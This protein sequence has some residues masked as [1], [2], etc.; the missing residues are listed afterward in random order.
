M[1]RT[2]TWLVLGAFLAGT[3]TGLTARA[4]APADGQTLVLV[5]TTSGPASFS[6]TIQGSLDHEHSRGFDGAFSARVD[7]GR[8]TRI[9][10]LGAEAFFYDSDPEAKVAQNRVK[11]CRPLG[12]CIVNRTLAYGIGIDSTDHGGSDVDNRLFVVE[13]GPANIQFHGQGWTLRKVPLRYRYVLAADADA[14]GAFTGVN[15]VEMFRRASLSGGPDGSAAS[16]EPPCS[17]STVGVAAEPVPR[18]AGTITLSGGATPQS[19][20]CPTNLADPVLTG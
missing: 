5:R 8:L 15:S 6:L 20:T 1:R 16:A 11:V 14:D 13:E 7:G 10:S 2:L 4:S 18:G 9:A 17:T 3:A 12:G 19:V